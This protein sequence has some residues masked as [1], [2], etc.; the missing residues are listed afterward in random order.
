M[1]YTWKQRLRFFAIG[2]ARCG[3]KAACVALVPLFWGTWAHNRTNWDEAL[4][5]ALGAFLLAVR[6]YY[7]EHKALLRLPPGLE[8]PPEFMDESGKFQIPPQAG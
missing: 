5:A 4:L 3:L 2:A 6:S 7:L 1:N 8:I